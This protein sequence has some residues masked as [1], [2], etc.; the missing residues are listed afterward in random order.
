MEQEL[1]LHKEQELEQHRAQE[2]GQHM[3]QVLGQDEHMEQGLGDKEQVQVHGKEQ[4]L[5]DMVQDQR[6]LHQCGTAHWS[7]DHRFQDTH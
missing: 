1:G 3:E 2:L 5:D 7:R 6:N 4:G